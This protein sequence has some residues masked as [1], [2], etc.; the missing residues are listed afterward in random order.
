[1]PSV[2]APPRPSTYWES[3]TCTQGSFLSGKRSLCRS[4]TSSRELPN[5]EGVT[6]A[7]L[8]WSISSKVGFRRPWRGGRWRKI[9]HLGVTPCV[10][11]MGAVYVSPADGWR[12]FN[13]ESRNNGTSMSQMWVTTDST[14]FYRVKMT[15]TVLFIFFLLTFLPPVIATF[16]SLRWQNLAYVLTGKPVDWQKR[17]IYDWEWIKPP[18]SDL[19]DLRNSKYG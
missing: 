4:I 5:R 12:A 16:C 19:E 9:Y 3:W 15:P 8:L 1:M 17:S 7:R 6:I 10:Q 13:F 14:C 2:W 11:L 18:T